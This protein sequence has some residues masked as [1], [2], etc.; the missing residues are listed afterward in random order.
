VTDT[1]THQGANRVLFLNNYSMDRARAAV[2]AGTY[3]RH[4]LWGA[5]S[6]QHAGIHVDYVTFAKH[7]RLHALSGKLS[8]HF[9][10]LSQQ[11]SVARSFHAGTVVY[12]GNESQTLST[13]AVLRRF[14]C[15][16]APTA[17]IFH[18]FVEPGSLKGTELRGYDVAISIVPAVQHHLITVHKR[19][20]ETAPLLPWGPDLRYAG[21]TST[22]DDFVL[23]SGKTRRDVDTLVQALAHVRCPAK[24][25]VSVPG[26]P[27]PRDVEI[28]FEGPN[29]PRSVER[30]LRQASVIVIPLRTPIWSSFG[31]TEINAALALGKPIVMTRTPFQ[32]FDLEEV[33][34]GIWV[35]P[36]DVDGWVDALGRLAADSSLRKEMGARGRRFAEDHLNADLFGQRLLQVFR[37]AFALS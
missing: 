23:S 19:D 27:T 4:H 20:P 6:L 10:D 2:N 15:W 9:G 21:Y 29:A 16:R 7:R 30:D 17:G 5:D 22:G 33:G 32:P 1:S 28:V 24:V 26:V 8:W 25:Y 34:C 13:L 12:T 35:D 14:G 37:N 31:L 36:G 3:P 11:L 18:S